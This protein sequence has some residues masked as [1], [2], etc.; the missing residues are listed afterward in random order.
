[1]PLIKEGRNLGV[2]ALMEVAGI[3]PRFITEEDIGFQISP[4]SMLPAAWSARI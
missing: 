2:K 4:G 3:N 1:M